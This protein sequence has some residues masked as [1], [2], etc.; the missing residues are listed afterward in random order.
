MGRRYKTRYKK[1]MKGVVKKSEPG[2]FAD[3]NMILYKPRPRQY[4]WKMKRV[5]YKK[6]KHYNFK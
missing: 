4:Y 5:N 1:F 6:A 3:Y 2:D